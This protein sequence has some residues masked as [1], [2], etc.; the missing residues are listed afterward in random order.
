ME[1][2]RTTYIETVFLLIS[3][4]TLL[5]I[6]HLFRSLTHPFYFTLLY[7]QTIWL[8]TSTNKLYRC[9]GHIIYRRWLALLWEAVWKETILS[10]RQIPST[11]VYLAASKYE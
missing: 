4:L 2:S 10:T 6:K 8:Y 7:D 3:A 11:L 1:S 5:V 9:F